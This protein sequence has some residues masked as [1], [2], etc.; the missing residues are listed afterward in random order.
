M[1]P[2]FDSYARR[3]EVSAR[4]ELAEGEEYDDA[5]TPGGLEIQQNMGEVI[6]FSWAERQECSCGVDVRTKKSLDGKSCK[7][8]IDRKSQG[9]ECG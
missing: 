9:C 8:R 2:Y 7:V 6:S 1:N 4:A 5:N 3:F